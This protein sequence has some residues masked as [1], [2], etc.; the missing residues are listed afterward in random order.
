ME[1]VENQERQREFT[2]PELVTQ[3]SYSYSITQTT[4][5]RCLPCLLPHQFLSTLSKPPKF[6]SMQISYKSAAHVERS[7][8]APCQGCDEPAWKT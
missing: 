4:T 3:S 5:P 2:C 7:N 8:A 1:M 6:C